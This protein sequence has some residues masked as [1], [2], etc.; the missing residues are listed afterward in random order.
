MS[1]IPGVKPPELKSLVRVQDRLTFLY[2]E[3]CI[4]NRSDNAITISDQRGTVHVPA[5][6]L[7]VL[8][9]G[10]G[11]NV[12]HAAISL[13]AESRSTC[14]WVGERGV[15]YYCHGA[16]LA[17]STHLLE[18]QAKLVSSERS[19]LKVARKMYE[20]RFPNEET[21]GLT[22][23]QLLGKEGTRVRRAYE[24]ESRRTGVQ[25]SGRSYKMTDFDE[26]DLINQA[27]SAVNTSLYGVVHAVI[28]SLGCS[29]DWDSCMLGM[30]V[31]SYMTLLIFTR[32]ISQFRWHSILRLWEWK[33]FPRRLGRHCG[34]A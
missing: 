9:L 30:S 16:S 29:R 32:R 4:V 8:M 25:W 13:L 34:I 17:S 18:E 11:S 31:A 24:R 19:R 10:P 33:M 26:A 3:H 1:K 15:R 7:S 21:A 14:I 27:L 23:Q 2:A 12:T 20:M 28:V 6:T 22:M 5:A